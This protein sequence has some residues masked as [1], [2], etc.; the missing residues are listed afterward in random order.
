[1]IKLKDI[2]FE[3]IGVTKLNEEVYDLDYIDD[4]YYESG[5]IKNHI[6]D[7]PLGHMFN[8][9]ILTQ[10][11]L[12]LINWYKT[13]RNV[14]KLFNKHL[15]N[16]FSVDGFSRDSAAFKKAAIAAISIAKAR[17]SKY[18]TLFE[19][20]IGAGPNKL[21]RGI[22]VPAELYDKSKI[23]N[24]E[25][26]SFTPLLDLAKE[27]A[28]DFGY[29]DTGIVL[30]ID[31]PI[32]SNFIINPIWSMLLSEEDVEELETFAANNMP[33]KSISVTNELPDED[34]YS[35]SEEDDYLAS[36]FPDMPYDTT[37]IKD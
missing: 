13:E 16:W 2:L 3:S 15:I 32:A 34:H 18:P 31:N 10:F 11:E 14:A 23:S 27:F 12:E 29:N 20:W 17:R 9:A 35:S 24:L 8:D 7:H 22:P 5:D 21:Y 36:I 25:G 19:P 33:F 28:T 26:Q 37:G 6:Q 30:V 1:M 4:E